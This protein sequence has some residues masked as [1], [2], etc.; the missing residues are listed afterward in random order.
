M[1][2]IALALAAT[3]VTQPQ[4]A[5]LEG[6]EFVDERWI[7]RYRL[8]D[9]QLLTSPPTSPETIPTSPASVPLSVPV[10]TTASST[11][12]AT[13][14]ALSLDPGVLTDSQASL[15][16][17]CA[18]ATWMSLCLPAQRVEARRLR[19]ESR[20]YEA[21]RLRVGELLSENQ[22]DSALSFALSGGYLGLARQAQA[23]CT[24]DPAPDQ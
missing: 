3:I 7:C 17:R 11:T 5:T 13:T 6:C 14:S 20:A 1:W 8:P 15:V 9:V 23:F 12:V 24:T 10:T 21:A 18:E 22:C 16:A 2:E 19:D 4:A